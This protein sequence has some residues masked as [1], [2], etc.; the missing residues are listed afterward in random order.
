MEYFIEDTTQSRKN[1]GLYIH[2]SCSGSRN[3]GNL[4]QGGILYGILSN[5]FLSELWVRLLQ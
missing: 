3:G 1:N 2:V 4:N 5:I